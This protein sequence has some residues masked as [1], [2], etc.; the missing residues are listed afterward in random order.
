MTMQLKTLV[1]AVA[2]VAGTRSRT[3]KIE[4][5]A[6]FLRQV[7]PEDLR[8]AIGLLVGKPP[9][10]RL[11]VGARGLQGHRQRAADRPTLGLGDVG[12]AFHGRGLGASVDRRA[13]LDA[14]W[15]H[16]LGHP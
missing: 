2:E 15:P 12:E 7:E 5:L 3:A 6:S 10:G 4:V 16:G 13:R 9:Q 14:S 11:G 1:D 8:T